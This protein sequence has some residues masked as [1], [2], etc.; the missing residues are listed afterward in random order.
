[1]LAAVPFWG[2]AAKLSRNLSFGSRGDDVKALQGFLAKDSALYPEG[3]LT[4]YFG[5]LTREAVKRFQTRE[6]IAPAEGYVGPKTRAR[7]NQLT[8]GNTAAEPPAGSETSP[9]KQFEDFQRALAELQTAS[10]T[11]TTTPVSDIVPPRFIAG[12]T[13]E[14]L[15][16]D[17]NSPFGSEAPMQII[18]NWQTDEPTAPFNISCSPQFAVSGLSL[19]ATYWARKA[20]PHSCSL[21]VEDPSG[22]RTTGIFAFEVPS[23]LGITGSS[24]AA[25]L[26]YTKLGD[27]QV[28]NNSTTSIV[29]FRIN[30]A[31]EDALD[32]PNS[33]GKNYKLILRDGAANQDPILTNL[34]VFLHSVFPQ[35]GTFHQHSESLYAGVTLAA[36]GA[37]TFSLWIEGLTGPLYGGSLKFKIP[38]ITTIPERTTVGSAELKF[39][40]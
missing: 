4:G 27:L 31:V 7:L 12:P 8:A 9:S 30:V 28:T 13:A 5:R 6:K 36:G 11:A 34:D 14:I 21:T 32:A 1:M 35:P 15:N 19:Q 26:E 23:W 3:L 38:S 17:S 40:R 29:V 37:R 2:H 18:V 22:N 39:S 25:L 20:G 33:R 10:T 16:P 24:T